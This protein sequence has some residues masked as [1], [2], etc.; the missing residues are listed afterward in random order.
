[1]HHT[2]WI[3]PIQHET[4]EQLTQ[5]LWTKGFDATQGTTSFYV[6]DPP[7]NRPEMTPTE[8]RK[9]FVRLLFIPVYVGVSLPEVQ[10]LAHAI[11]DFD[12]SNGFD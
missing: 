9:A 7:T 11:S 10:R 4:P 2:H 12:A 3:F 5:F 1:M 6:V 8:A